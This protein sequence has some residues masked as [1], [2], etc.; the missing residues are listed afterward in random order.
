[1]N[2]MS[3]G[4][5]AGR[6][7]DRQMPAQSG[8]LR[9]RADRAPLSRIWRFAGRHHRRL[10]PFVGVSVVGA[11][12]ALATPMQTGKVVDRIVGGGAPAF[13]VGLA[14]IIAVVALAEAA[15]SLRSWTRCNSAARTTRTTSRRAVAVNRLPVVR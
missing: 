2:V 6:T 14:A 5:V 3:M 1:V 9:K 7:L 11:L 12:L 8:Q 13:V 10:G 15:V 4:S